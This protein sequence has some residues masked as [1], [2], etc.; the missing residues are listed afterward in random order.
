MD[1]FELVFAHLP[2]RYGINV[3]DLLDWIKVD[4]FWTQGVVR[5]TLRLKPLLDSCTTSQKDSP[6]NPALGGLS[7]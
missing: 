2:T 5:I 3:K 6:K 1:Y 4:E 7:L